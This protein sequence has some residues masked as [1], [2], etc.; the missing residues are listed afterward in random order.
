[1]LT[2]ESRLFR[3][4][5]RRAVAERAAEHASTPA[6]QVEQCELCSAVVPSEHQHLLDVS[7]RR[8]VCSCRAC[9]MLFDGG[10][11]GGRQYRLIPDRVRVLRTVTNADLFWAELAIPVDLAFFFFDTA[12]KRMVALYPGPMGATESQLTL[13]AWEE[14]AVANPV[15]RQLQPDVEAL[16]VNRTRN[17]S[18]HWLV[19]IDACY[20][21]AGVIR[22]HWKGLA[23]GEAVWTELERCFDGIRKRAEEVDIS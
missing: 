6:E 16:L 5:R 12:A 11:I 10:S 7:A 17:R 19:P 9:S 21:L 13:A 4:A 15:L 22:S 20:T 23:G 2:E 14:F 8:L 18:E 3:M 1:M